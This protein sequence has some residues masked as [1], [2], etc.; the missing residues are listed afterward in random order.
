MY[1][2]LLQ[3]KHSLNWIEVE[4]KQYVI[5][6]NPDFTF[7]EHHVLSL[8]GGKKE[9]EEETSMDFLEHIKAQ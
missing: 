3:S 6:T 1:Q 4:W 7:K 9:E 8:Q 5:Q 2:K